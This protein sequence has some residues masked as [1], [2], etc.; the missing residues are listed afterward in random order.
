MKKKVRRFYKRFRP[1]IEGIS[2]SCDYTGRHA[3]RLYPDAFGQG[4]DA[5]TSAWIDV[6]KH[7]QQAMDSLNIK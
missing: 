3:V 7:M 2:L 1:F 4:E 6:G 5:L